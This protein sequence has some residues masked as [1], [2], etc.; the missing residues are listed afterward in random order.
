MLF[1]V[2]I[3]DVS[4]QTTTALSLIRLITQFVKNLFEITHTICIPSDS[5]LIRFFVE[6]V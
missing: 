2:E 5:L 4:R 1:E 3:S 6:F